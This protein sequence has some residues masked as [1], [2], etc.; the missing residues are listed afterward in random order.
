[1]LWIVSVL[2]LAMA[3]FSLFATYSLIGGIVQIAV[4]FTLAGFAIHRIW[5]MRA[6]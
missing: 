2:L 6:G 3:V 5:R 1:M 4:I